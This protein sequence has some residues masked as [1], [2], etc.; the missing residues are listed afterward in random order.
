VNRTSRTQS[1]CA[2]HER[3]RTHEEEVAILAHRLDPLGICL[4][5]RGTTNRKDAELGFVEGHVAQ[6]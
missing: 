3:G 5:F 6:G 4:L 2:G 1:A